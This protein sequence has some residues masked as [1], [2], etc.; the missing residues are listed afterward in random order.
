MTEI[1]SVL[2]ETRIFYPPQ[3]GKDKALEQNL[4]LGFL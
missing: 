1:K 2:R 3:E 4:L